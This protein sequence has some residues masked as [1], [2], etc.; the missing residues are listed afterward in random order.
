MPSLPAST[1]RTMVSNAASNADSSGIPFGLGCLRLP[2]DPLGQ[3]RRDFLVV[4]ELEREVTAPAGNRAQVGGVAE[5]LG[6][7]DVGADHLRVAFRLGAEDLAT[8]AV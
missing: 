5:H 1:A 8:A 7:R 4:G 2:D 3:V 6:H